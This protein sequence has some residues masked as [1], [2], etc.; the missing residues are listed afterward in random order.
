MTIRELLRATFKEN[1]EFGCLLLVIAILALIF[2]CV[3]TGMRS[4]SFEPLAY[5][6]HC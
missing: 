6:M 5:A 1:N 2:G 4:G 3:F